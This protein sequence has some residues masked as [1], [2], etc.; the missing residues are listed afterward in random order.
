MQFFRT[1]GYILA[2]IVV[3]GVLT[4]GGALVMAI[5]TLVGFALSAMAI[6]GFVAYCIKEY[7]EK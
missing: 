1:L 6:V 7:C 3:V 2:A 5:V 4:A